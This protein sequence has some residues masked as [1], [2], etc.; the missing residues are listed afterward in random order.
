[1]IASG[2]PFSPSTTAIRTSWIP[3]FFSSFITDYKE[4]FEDGYSGNSYP[5]RKVVLGLVFGLDEIMEAGRRDGVVKR[6]RGVMP[7]SW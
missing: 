3:Q 1:M 7:E 5:L 4:G 2:K 6:E